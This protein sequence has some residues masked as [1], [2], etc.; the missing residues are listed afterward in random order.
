MTD[1]FPI[2]FIPAN[3]PEAAALNHIYA[4]SQQIRGVFMDQTIWLD[5]M[6][7]DILASYFVTDPKKRALLSSDVL[8]GP[9]QTF[10]GRISLLQKIVNRSYKAF[11][12]EHPNLFDRLG[13]IR[14]FRNRL[15]HSHLD[16]SDEFLGKGYTDR[17][18]INFFKNGEELSQ[19]I[20]VE[21]S[22]QRL[23]ECSEVL[24]QLVK[25]QTLVMADTST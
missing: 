16:T 9:D 24:L 15:A 5:V 7:T 12:D 19:A 23:K 2:P 20:T 18:Q 11:A 1:D 25:L 8:S 13:K 3:S 21:D 4:L 10:S 17:I 22:R 6:I 14:Q